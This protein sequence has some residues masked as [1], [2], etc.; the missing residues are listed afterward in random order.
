MGADYLGGQFTA[1]CLRVRHLVLCRLPRHVRPGSAARRAEAH[2][3]AQVPGICPHGTTIV[4]V[5]FDGGVMMA[6]DRRATAGQHDRPAGHREGVPQ[7][8]VLLRRHRRRGRASP[9]SSSGCSSSSSST[10]RSSRAGPCRWRARPTGWP[11]SS[12]ATSAAPCR[13]WS[14]CRCSPGTTR[15]R[16]GPDLQLR[17]RRRPVRGARVPLHRLR[18]GVRPRLAE[19][20]LRRGHVRRRRGQR[21]HAG[22]LRRG[23]RRLRHRRPGPDPAD[24][25]GGGHGHRGRVPAADRRGGRRVRAGGR[26]RADAVARRSALARCGT[27][28]VPPSSSPPTT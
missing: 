8:R 25:P 26:R 21:V 5:D 12:A 15:S 22:A 27:S 16:Q 10:T 18:L 24:L 4:A 1:A 6:G 28:P 3:P 19:E 7:R 17:R 14:W 11:R 2:G 13:A 23:R 9:S 20:A